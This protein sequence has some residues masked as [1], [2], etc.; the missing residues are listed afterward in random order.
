MEKG[1]QI[2][3]GKYFEF[4]CHLAAKAGFDVVSINFHDAREELEE[5]K[6]IIAFNINRILG[7]TGLKCYQTHLPYTYTSA[8][9]PDEKFDFVK[10]NNSEHYKEPD[11]KQPENVSVDTAGK[12]REALKKKDLEREQRKY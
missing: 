10:R 9:L 7:E 6:S 4:K 11:E 8:E 5:K 1:I 3:Y 12:P 2:D